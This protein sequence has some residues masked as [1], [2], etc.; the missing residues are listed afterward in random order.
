MQRSNWSAATDPDTAARRAGR[1]RH[2]KLRKLAAIS[3]SMKVLELLDTVSPGR[4]AKAQIARQ[5][6][7]HRSTITRDIQRVL[8]VARG[9]YCPFCVARRNRERLAE[10]EAAAQAAE[11]FRDNDQ[12]GASP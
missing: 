9:R 11:A 6:G 10:A 2:N 12:A 3:R 8:N 7:V 1:R 5:L 4:G